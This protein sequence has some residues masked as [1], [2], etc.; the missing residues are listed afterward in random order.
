MKKYIISLALFSAFSVNAQATKVAEIAIEFS[1]K[2]CTPV[3]ISAANAWV[4]LKE[5]KP[6]SEV[7]TYLEKRGDMHAKDIH[8]I[9]AKIKK[10][11]SK[12]LGKNQLQ[13]IAENFQEFKSMFPDS[14]T[15]E[16]VV[17]YGT[18]KYCQEDFLVELIG[19][20]TVDQSM[21][22]RALNAQ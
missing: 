12:N 8:K 1:E 20:E 17:F 11:P 10:S 3:G 21:L 14:D 19:E 22:L 13:A 9:L 18:R 5:G 2:Y 7:K 15:R 6:H 4:M 16:L